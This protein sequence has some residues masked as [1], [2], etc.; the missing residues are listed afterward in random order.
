MSEIQALNVLD[1]ISKTGADGLMDCFSTDQIILADI[2]RA[3]HQTMMLALNQSMADVKFIRI[4]LAQFSRILPYDD[5]SVPFGNASSASCVITPPLM[6]GVL[7]AVIVG[8]C[9]L[10]SVSKP[11]FVFSSCMFL[12]SNGFAYF[13]TIVRLKPDSPLVHS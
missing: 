13:I 6:P 8:D 1:S 9:H 5:P 2:Y 11:C 12:N 4:L 3:A 7:S 10:F